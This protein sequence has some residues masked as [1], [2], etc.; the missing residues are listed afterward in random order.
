MS[1]TPS[2][3]S[4][5]GRTLTRLVAGLAAVILVTYLGFNAVAYFSSRGKI[6]N[7]RSQ[8]T[9]AI[10]DARPATEAHQAQVTASLGDPDHA[11]IEQECVQGSRDRGW[12][13]YTYTSTCTLRS[14]EAY[15]VADVGDCVLLGLVRSGEG[16]QVGSVEVQS[17]F[18]PAEKAVPASRSSAR[19]SRPDVSRPHLTQPAAPTLTQ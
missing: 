18:V 1:S 10:A 12:T 6:A 16:Y 13:V 7:A 9:A 11:W 3:G 19:C 2:R 17:R 4:R 8:T 14:V 5:I 15:A